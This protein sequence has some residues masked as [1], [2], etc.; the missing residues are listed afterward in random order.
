[1]ANLSVIGDQLGI[2]QAEL[3]TIRASQRLFPGLENRLEELQMA[4][5]I[6][7][8]NV[9]FL[10]AQLSQAMITAAS[11]SPYVDVVDPAIGATP[12]V[13]RGKLNLVLGALRGAHP[14]NRGG[15]LPGIP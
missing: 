7:A 13:P 4:Q 6:D 1:M 10:R 11:A 9:Q 15:V 5:G 8:Q 3:E 14:G 12:A 2:R